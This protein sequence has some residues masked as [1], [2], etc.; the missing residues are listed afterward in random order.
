VGEA[1]SCLDTPADSCGDQAG[2]SAANGCFEGEHR[3]ECTERDPDDCAFVIGCSVNTRVGPDGELLRTCRGELR[4][5][6]EIDNEGTCNG[7]L[8]SWGDFCDGEATPCSELTASECAAQAGC[9][10]SR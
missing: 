7:S 8:C 3:T 2:C 9:T 6:S 5:C 4:T 10:P 1:V